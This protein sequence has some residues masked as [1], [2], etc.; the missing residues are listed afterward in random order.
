MASHAT[1]GALCETMGNLDPSVGIFVTTTSSANF[2]VLHIGVVHVCTL[3]SRR[4]MILPHAN[5]GSMLRLDTSCSYM[6]RLDTSC[7]YIA[8]L[9]KHHILHRV[10]SAWA[11]FS[12]RASALMV[13]LM[14]CLL[15][16]IVLQPIVVIEQVR[17]HH[18]LYD[19]GRL[20]NQLRELFADFFVWP[21]LFSLN[22]LQMLQHVLEGGIFGEL[23]EHLTEEYSVKLRELGSLVVQHIWPVVLAVDKRGDSFFLPQEV[24]WCQPQPRAQCS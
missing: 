4:I 15:H 12:I 17:L 8:T 11:W 22:L 5:C 20:C 19:S 2:A 6:L 24:L 7:S 1:S 16:T 18:L 10:M 21:C 9:L 13:R 23:R 14:R 3:S